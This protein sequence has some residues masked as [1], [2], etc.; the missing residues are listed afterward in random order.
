MEKGERFFCIQIHANFWYAEYHHD[1]AIRQFINLYNEI[2]DVFEKHDGGAACWDFETQLTL[3][4]LSDTG[5][6]YLDRLNRLIQEGSHDVLPCT[7][8][9]TLATHHTLDEFTWNFKKSVERMKKTFSR[10]APTWIP[11]DG[12]FSPQFVD[13]MKEQGMEYLLWDYR[14]LN[15]HH[16]GNYTLDQRFRPILVKGM[17]ETMPCMT[18]GIEGLN[19]SGDYQDAFKRQ[20]KRIDNSEYADLD[21]FIY[22]FIDGERIH[23]PRFDNWLTRI[24]EA[25]GK[26]IT[27]SNFIK[28]NLPEPGSKCFGFDVGDW[29][30][31]SFHN[32]TYLD[33]KLWTQVEKTRAK[34]REAEWWIGTSKNNLQGDRNSDLVKR[35][36][37]DLVIAKQENILAQSSDKTH[38]Y[39]C[40]HKLDI[41]MRYSVAAYEK[42][43]YIC[44]VL[45]RLVTKAGFS[46]P[47]RPQS[48]KSLD[49]NLTLLN[50]FHPSITYP[51]NYPVALDFPYIVVV[52]LSTSPAY[53]IEFTGQ[54]R[55]PEKRPTVFHILPELDIHNHRTEIYFQLGKNLG[56][57]E[58][59]PLRLNH[60]NDEVDFDE[61][62]ADCLENESLKVHLSPLGDI[63]SIECKESGKII[64]SPNNKPLLSSRFQSEIIGAG[65]D[66]FELKDTD[67]DMENSRFFIKQSTE[68]DGQHRLESSTKIRVFPGFPGVMVD[69]LATI[70]GPTPGYYCPF[71][72]DWENLDAIT[73]DVVDE[74][75]TTRKIDGRQVFINDWFIASAGD[76][77]VGFAVDKGIH[78]CKQLL[79]ERHKDGSGTLVSIGFMRHFPQWVAQHLLQGVIHQ[80]LWVVPFP[81][82][83]ATGERVNLIRSLSQ[84][85]VRGWYL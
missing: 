74:P 7:W 6:E 52:N 2:L 55:A 23:P 21:H 84:P 1:Q 67:C 12:G 51:R 30:D 85:P 45:S 10:V 3:K 16:A 27:P 71:E 54:Q 63:T 19:S 72:F 48:M 82:N 47:D 43:S 5:T 35:F 46:I 9:T 59:L 44:G 60:V 49:L 41:G 81:D 22:T 28:E 15:R 31:W 14:L 34:I 29:H 24:E 50:P 13:Y 58:S 4:I 61:P 32:D 8:A 33:Q 70:K 75:L 62:A 38:W 77:S 20:V 18:F 76:A 56:Y 69:S 17:K 40:K 26:Y 36:K 83:G 25:G 42:A 68:K 73:R 39:A 57:G 11:Q 53:E 64:E 66:K 80:R 37:S 79:H 65:F 78:S